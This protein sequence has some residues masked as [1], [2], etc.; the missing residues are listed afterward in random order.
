VECEKRYAQLLKHYGFEMPA[1]RLGF[2][3]MV[4]PF[5]VY[6]RVPSTHQLMTD[7]QHLYWRSVGDHLRRAMEQYADKVEAH[8]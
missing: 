6:Y 4:S 5:G 1:R 3:R 7:V 8:R 2:T